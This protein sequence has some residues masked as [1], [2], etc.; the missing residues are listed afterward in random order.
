MRRALFVMAL[1]ACGDRPYVL[2]EHAICEYDSNI[3]TFHAVYCDP[4]TQTGCGAGRKCTWIAAVQEGDGDPGVGCV[5]D[6]TVPLGAAC[7]FSDAGYDN[8]AKG[9]FCGDGTCNAICSYTDPTTCGSGTACVPDRA[10][11]VQGLTGE[12]LCWRTC[13]PLADNDFDGSGSALSRSGSGCGSATMGCYGFPGRGMA[14]PTAFACYG[15]LN[16]SVPLRHRSECTSDSGCS[17]PLIGGILVNSCNQGYEPVLRE[18]TAVSTT[19]CVALCAPLDCYAGNCGSNDVNRV[20]AAPHRCN[21]IDARGSFGS[22]EE[23]QY[24]WHLEVDGSG[25]WLP[26]PYSNAVGFCVDRDAYGQPRCNTLP[27]AAAAA[28]GCVSTTTAGM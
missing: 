6:G 4:F 22:G 18:S 25:A 15:E 12:G 13:D 27:L 2:C 7:K 23:C 1:A 14:P 10:L 24:L 26:S 19:I 28:Q 21:A 3:D 17:V 20:G 8:C 5:P 16:A 9:L 11:F